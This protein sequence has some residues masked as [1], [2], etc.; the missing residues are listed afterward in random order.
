MFKLLLL[1]QY[2]LR[3]VLVHLKLGRR[4]KGTDYTKIYRHSF[5]ALNLKWLLYLV[6][7]IPFKLLIRYNKYFNIEISKR[8]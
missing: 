4:I 5:A 8:K 7:V 1:D 6:S 3:D 2:S